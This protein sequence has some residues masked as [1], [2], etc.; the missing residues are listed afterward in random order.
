MLQK[1]IDGCYY[2]RSNAKY[3]C[4]NTYA[5]KDLVQNDAF[6]KPKHWLASNPFGILDMDVKDI[7]DFILFFGAI[8]CSFW[9]DPK[10]TV[11]SEYGK[12]D[13]AYALIYVLFKLRKEKGHL[14]FEEITFLEF[15]EALKGNVDVP[16][17][18]ERYDRASIISKIVNTKMHGSFYLYTKDITDSEELFNLIVD[19]FS[20]LEDVRTFDDKPIYF[21]KLTQ[22]ITSDVL[23]IR[24]IMENINVNYD[25]LV[26]CADYKIPQVLRALGVLEYNEELASLIDK[27]VEIPQNSQY[28]TE[29]RACTIVAIDMIKK[30]LNNKIPAI[31]I[32]D[33]IWNL[34]QD[35][36]RDYKPYHL[37]RTMDY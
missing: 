16:L 31:D 11:K 26:G 1:I 29:I 28:E 13:G 18:K 5:I 19:N 4:I 37:T 21:Y 2:V 25:A 36:T 24:E 17:L 8:D 23:H 3:V 30:A 34:G 12:L 9:G 6:V 27:K 33:M 32:N 35:K 10:W 15:S 22:L 20:C 7:V 14:N